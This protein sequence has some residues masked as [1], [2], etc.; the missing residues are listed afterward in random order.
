MRRGSS[1]PCSAGVSSAGF[2]GELRIAIAMIPSRFCDIWGSGADPGRRRPRI[3]RAS[4]KRGG[5]TL[6][7]GGP[8]PRD[9]PTMAT[10]R[11]AD[12]GKRPA[13]GRLS[14]RERGSRR[15]KGRFAVGNRF[16]VPSGRLGGPTRVDRRRRP[17]QGRAIRG[18]ATP[19]YGVVVQAA[20]RGFRPRPSR[21]RAPP[22]TPAMRA[23]PGAG[24]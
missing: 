8:R 23:A 17:N 15:P 20:W 19:S 9:S 11:R 10:F 4:S 14:T 2:F 3:Y 24:P 16:D 22:T 21:M 1:L 18:P 13:P 12:A 6:G 7:G 5:E